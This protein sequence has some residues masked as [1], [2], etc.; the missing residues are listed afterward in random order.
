MKSRRCI[1]G[2]GHETD[3][4]TAMPPARAKSPATIYQAQMAASCGAPVRDIPNSRHTS[5][6]DSPSSR[7]PM[8][9]RR[10]SITE[11]TFHGIYTSRIESAGKC[12]PCAVRNGVHPY[13]RQEI[14]NSVSGRSSLKKARST[15]ENRMCVLQCV[16]QFTRW[17]AE[18][19]RPRACGSR[20]RQYADR[21]AGSGPGGCGWRPR[22]GSFTTPV[23]A[24]AG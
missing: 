1:Q 4:D 6:I 21:G 16:L 20:S 7:R 9:R 14:G 13:M 3:G 24:Y 22:R 23:V 11:L 15:S 5:D 19:D 2:P 8:K 18:P 10:S 17:R 12:N